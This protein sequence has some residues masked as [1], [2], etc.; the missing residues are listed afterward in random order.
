MKIMRTLSFIVVLV[1]CSAFASLANSTIPFKAS[2][3]TVEYGQGRK[4]I[5]TLDMQGLADGKKRYQIPKVIGVEFVFANGKTAKVSEE[6]LAGI[7]IVDIHASMIETGI[8]DGTWFLTT[9]IKNADGIANRVANDWVVFV[10]ESYKYEKRWL[11][12]NSEQNAEITKAERD[13]AR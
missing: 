13:S 3:I 7:E 6:G 10:F 2:K 4:A 8:E 9:R 11:E 5:F 1:L 12:R